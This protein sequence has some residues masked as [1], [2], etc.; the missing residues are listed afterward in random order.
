[1]LQRQTALD[2]PSRQAHPAQVLP[3]PTQELCPVIV[4]RP[5]RFVWE[6]ALRG[7]FDAPLARQ[8]HHLLR[9]VRPQGCFPHCLV[10]L[11]DTFALYYLRYIGRR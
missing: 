10:T 8:Q 2:T 4:Y 3:P 1:M 7:N 6:S 5:S 9:R 11:V